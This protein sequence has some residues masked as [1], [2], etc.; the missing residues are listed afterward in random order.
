[1]EG[2]HINVIDSNGPDSV[3]ESAT[4]GVCRYAGEVETAVLWVTKETSS[5]GAVVLFNL[6][7]GMPSI[8]LAS[9][10]LASSDAPLKIIFV[11]T[12]LSASTS[13]KNSEDRFV[14]EA[15]DEVSSRKDFNFL[16]DGTSSNS[17]FLLYSRAFIST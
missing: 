2:N 14:E 10:S 6:E 5:M 9:G 15:I 8:L 11:P 7:E 4:E 3:T 16:R 12:V 1:V 13:S 17:M